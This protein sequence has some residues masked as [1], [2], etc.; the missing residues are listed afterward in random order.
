M[1]IRTGIELDDRPGPSPP[2]V[3]DGR[4]QDPVWQTGRRPP[5]ARSLADAVRYC[6][7]DGAER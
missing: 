3:G 4:S 1:R 6:P 5:A 7:A 2:V